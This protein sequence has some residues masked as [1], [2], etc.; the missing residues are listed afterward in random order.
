MDWSR[1]KTIFIIVFSILNIFLYTLYV[2]RYTEA[3][4]FSDLA[5]PQVDERLDGDN[6]TYP[7]DLQS[8]PE[9]EPYISGTRQAFTN[10]QVLVEDAKATIV[11]DYLLDVSFDEPINLGEDPDTESLEDFLAANVYEGG[12]YTLW[13]VVEEENKAIF[14]QVI[15]EKTLYHSDSGSVTLYWN[16][17]GQAVRYEQTLFTN[18]VENE[19]AKD[20]ISPKRAIETLYQNGMLQQNSAITSANLGYSVYV[21]VSDDTRMFLPTWRFIVELEDGSTADYYVNAIKDGVIEF[22]QAEEEGSE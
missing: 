21:A 12:K 14:F 6:I 10:E 5:E 2:D 19:Q 18:L 7:E 20:L 13:D 16:E 1:T 8:D 22:K 9:E 4:N 15:N 17:E 11:E 3:E